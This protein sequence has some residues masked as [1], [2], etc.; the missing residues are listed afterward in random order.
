MPDKTVPT[1]SADPLAGRVDRLEAMVVE[2]ADRVDKVIARQQNAKALLR[3]AI[4]TLD[5]EQDAS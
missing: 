2:A 3:T 4:R 5:G 1:R